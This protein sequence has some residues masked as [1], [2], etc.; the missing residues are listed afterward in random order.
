MWAGII[1]MGWIGKAVA[2]RAHFGFGM[3]ICFYNCS[4]SVMSMMAKAVQMGSVAEV[5]ASSDF[6]S[7]HCA[8]SPDTFQILVLMPFS[9]A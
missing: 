5:C 7:L 6:V 3:Q 1:G 8:A 2:R 9:T 4:L